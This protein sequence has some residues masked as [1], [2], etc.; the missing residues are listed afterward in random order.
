MVCLPVLPMRV[1]T[2]LGEWELEDA[3][4]LI[5]VARWSVRPSRRPQVA[6]ASRWWFLQPPVGR[7]SWL[8]AVVAWQLMLEDQQANQNW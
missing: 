6:T 1:K 3:D 5:G 4:G 8:E 7:W 2:G